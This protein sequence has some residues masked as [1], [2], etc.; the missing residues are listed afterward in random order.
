[1]ISVKLPGLLI[2]L[3]LMTILMPLCRQTLAAEA[4]VLAI[5]PE[6]LKQMPHESE[7]RLARDPFNWPAGQIGKLKTA[8]ET[9]SATDVFQ[10]IVLSGIIWDDKRPL[11]IINGQLTAVG[12]K[13]NLTKV[14]EISRKEVVLEYRGARHIIQFEAKPTGLRPGASH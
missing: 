12:D 2:L 10:G 6:L 4:A 3:I 14:A 13:V 11:A 9:K 1:M 5:R 8:E 7:S